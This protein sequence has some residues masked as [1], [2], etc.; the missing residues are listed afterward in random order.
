M[1]KLN[2]ALNINKLTYLKKYVFDFQIYFKHDFQI[3]I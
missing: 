3:C 2:V 1:K